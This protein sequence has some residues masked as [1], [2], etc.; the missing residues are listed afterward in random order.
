VPGRLTLDELTLM[1]EAALAGAGLAYLDEWTVRDHIAAGRLIP[2]LED[3]SPPF[4]GL[5]LYY[6]GRRHVPAGLRAL[7]VLIREANTAA[8]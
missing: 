4:P 3:W 6:P 1:T 7:V 2:A 8:A 5:C